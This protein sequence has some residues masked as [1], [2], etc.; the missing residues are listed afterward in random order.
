VDEWGCAFKNEQAGII[1]QV[2]QPIVENW[3]D[4]DKLRIPEELLTVDVDKV[5]DFCR[6][7]DK[8]VLASS[9]CPRPFERLQF[10]RGTTNVYMDLAIKSP[11]LLDL[12][13]QIHQF[14]IKELELW[15]ETDIDALMFMDDWGGQ[16]SLLISPDMWRHLFKPL[17]RE[18]INIAH[19]H[20]K[21]IFMHSDGK[22]IDIMPDLIE[23][24]LDALNSQIFCM[25]VEELGRRFKGKITFWGEI[26]RQHILANGSKDEIIDAVKRVKSS[27]YQNGGVIAQCEFGPGAK[28]EN[29]E[30]VF[31]TWNRL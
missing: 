24:G 16:G 20:R 31:E 14:Y 4:L 2:K 11:V 6:N 18:Y 1:G 25:D 7:T 13:N 8:F 26:D 19:S 17:Y 27:L 10:I 5:N 29:I 15:A 9:C 30:L 22:I 23:L 12:L 3:E 28:P 21:K